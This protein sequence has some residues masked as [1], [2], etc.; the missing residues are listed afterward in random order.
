MKNNKNVK[1][2]SEFLS[3]TF[4]FIL[5]FLIAFSFSWRTITYI[6]EALLEK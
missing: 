1:I 6:I 5:G 4:G 2:S 3:L